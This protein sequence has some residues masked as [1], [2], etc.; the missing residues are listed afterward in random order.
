MVTVR[1]ATGPDDR[2]H[3]LALRRVVFIDEQGVP[4]ADEIDDLDDACTHF[5]AIDDAGRAVGTARLRFVDDVAKVQRVA[6]LREGRNR[7]VG[8]ALMD[9]LER[10]ASARGARV[11]K[12]AAQT[13]AIPFYERLAYEAYGDIFDDAGI[14]HRQMRKPLSPTATRG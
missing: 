11:A 9:A 8:R 5:L 12:L 10:E 14:P 4:E 13:S 7:G 1:I 3:C 2:G 6:V